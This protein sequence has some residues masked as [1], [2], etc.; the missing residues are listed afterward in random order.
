MHFNRNTQGLAQTSLYKYPS[1]FLSIVFGMRGLQIKVLL[2]SLLYPIYVRCL[3]G[4]HGTQLKNLQWQLLFLITAGSLLRSLLFCNVIKG[5]LVIIYHCFGTT[6]WSHLQP[7]S[8]G[9][10]QSPLH[11]STHVR[12]NH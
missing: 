11:S 9:L 4:N 1:F 3:S 7:A 5:T 8:S 10:H 6:Y 2:S 12:H